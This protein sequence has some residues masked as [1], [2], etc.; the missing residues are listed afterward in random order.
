MKMNLFFQSCICFQKI[1]IS[2]ANGFDS[3]KY[4]L[5]FAILSI[6]PVLHLPAI[7]FADRALRCNGSLVY[8]GD[9]KAEVLSVCGK[10]DHVEHWEEVPHGHTFQIFDYEKERY[11]LPERIKG[12]IRFERWTYDLGSNRFTRYLLFQ[13]G[14]L[15]KI[16]RGDK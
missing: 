6:L 2:H 4:R 3:Q 11:Q 12:P 9:M 7:A 8:I 5:L 1:F 13:N 16:E 15:Y 10:P 14:E